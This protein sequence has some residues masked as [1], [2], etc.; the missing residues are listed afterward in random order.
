MEHFHVAC[1]VI[2]SNIREMISSSFYYSVINLHT[3]WHFNL[4]SEDG[5]CSALVWKEGVKNSQEDWVVN[6]ELAL[7]GTTPFSLKNPPPPGSTARSCHGSFSPALL[8]EW[9]AKYP[10]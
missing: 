8:R 4:A 1:R 9:S 3:F 2:M 10:H 6:T 7:V 5:L